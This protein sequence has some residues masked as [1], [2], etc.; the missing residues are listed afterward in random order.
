MTDTAFRFP[1]SDGRV[2]DRALASLAASTARTGP[3]AVPNVAGVGRARLEGA[4][5]RLLR[6]VASGLVEAIPT[7]GARID[8][9]GRGLRASFR[10]FGRSLVRS[11]LESL[12]ATLADALGEALPA[13]LGGGRASGGGSLGGSLLRAVLPSFGGGLPFPVAPG[14]IPISPFGGLAR[15]GRVAPGRAFLVGEAG[16][17]LFVPSTAGEIVPNARLAAAPAVSVVQNFDLR[18][19][20]LAAVAALRRESARI[21]REL[22]AEIAASARR[23]GTFA[24][25]PRV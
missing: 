16:P 18:G 4:I 13:L 1:A 6:A 9:L 7:T 21:K 8:G 2:L 17:E 22:V 20:D 10:S 12:Q 25:L 5:D 14:G 3:G 19:A 15:G 11:V 24:R 23:G